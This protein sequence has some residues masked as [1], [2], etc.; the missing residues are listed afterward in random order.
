LC[1]IESKKFDKKY[2]HP[3][4]A[5]TNTLDVKRFC[6]NRNYLSLGVPITIGFN[7]FT[8]KEIQ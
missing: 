6:N 7:P 3:I 5:E 8:Q 1:T 2:T 4:A